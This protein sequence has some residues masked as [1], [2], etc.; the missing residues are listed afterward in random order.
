MTHY[1]LSYGLVF[2]LAVLG[3]PGVHSVVCHLRITV[4]LSTHCSYNI[5]QTSVISHLSQAYCPD[6]DTVI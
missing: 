1:L 6:H 5:I 4:P 3:T 2:G